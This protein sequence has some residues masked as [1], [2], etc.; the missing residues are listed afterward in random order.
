MLE[1]REVIRMV[2][3]LVASTDQP[4]VLRGVGLF[5]A[6]LKLKPL[7]LDYRDPVLVVSQDGV[8]TKMIVAEMA[9]NFRTIGSCLVNHCGND[10]VSQGARPFAFLDYIGGDRV[11]G[12]TLKEIMVGVV[13]AAQEMGCAVVGGET[14]EMS[15]IYRERRH[16]LVGMMLGI[17]EADWIIDGSKIRPEDQLIGLGSNGLHT[18]GYSRA[19]E[20]LFGEHNYDLGT[21]IPGSH[22]SLQEELLRVHRSYVPLILR[23]L[24]E[25]NDFEVHGIAHITSGGI[26]ANLERILPRG[27]RAVIEKRFWQVPPIFSFLQAEGKVSEKEM[28]RTFN[29]GIGMILVVPGWKAG[30]VAERI[31]PFHR[32]VFPLGNIVAGERGVEII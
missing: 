17:S 1:K 15:D 4:W 24:E 29:M 2:K 21:E 3:N 14:A 25:G 8:G 6:L 23:L 16:E 12:L 22:S 5:S 11:S 7:L 18:N 20:I 30:T 28:F 32:L 13:K 26:L 27:C 9:G 19:R 31:D 10:V